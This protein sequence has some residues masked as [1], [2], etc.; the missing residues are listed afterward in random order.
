MRDKNAGAGAAF[1]NFCFAVTLRPPALAV[2]DA[3]PTQWARRAIQPG[4]RTR[5]QRRAANSLC[6]RVRVGEQRREHTL[7]RH[8][9]CGGKSGRGCALN[10]DSDLLFEWGGLPS[11][12]VERLSARCEIDEARRSFLRLRSD[13]AS[14]GPVSA[15]QPSPCSD[16]RAAACGWMGRPD[17]RRRG[18]PSPRQSAPRPL[19]PISK[20]VP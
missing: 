8:A 9:I 7:D 1:S 17:A 16:F 19:F 3:N 2:G 12:V 20:H 14:R 13:R 15:R 18:R 10:S 5:I 11:S 6:R 4:Q